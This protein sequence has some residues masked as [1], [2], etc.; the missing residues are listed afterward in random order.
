MSRDVRPGYYFSSRLPNL[1]LTIQLYLK[2]YSVQEHSEFKHI[3]PCLSGNSNVG[4]RQ[5]DKLP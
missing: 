3:V 2:T 4:N 5:S 1:K